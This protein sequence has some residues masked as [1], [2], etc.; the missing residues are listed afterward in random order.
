MTCPLCAKDP[1]SHSLDYFGTTA[2]GESLYYTAPARATA[3]DTAQSILC[4]RDHLHEITGPWIWVLD[5]SNMELHTMYSMPFST[6]FAE[7]LVTEHARNLRNIVILYP[8]G[9]I[10][11]V[12]HSL[13]M[14]VLERIHFADTKQ[15]I[16]QVC[17]EVGV[18]SDA[19]NWLLV[20][21]TRNPNQFLEKVPKAPIVTAPY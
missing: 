5:C 3:R 19:R 1:F 9:W 13:R 18:S 20:T 8:N 16:L 2:R 15:D 4:L 14:N 12:L 11:R 10:Y 7:F 17:N 21:L 6:I